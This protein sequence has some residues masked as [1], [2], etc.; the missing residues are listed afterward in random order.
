MNIRI[1]VI[2]HELLNG[3]LADTMLDTIL[4]TFRTMRGFA[5]KADARVAAEPRSSDGAQLWSVRSIWMTQDGLDGR[6]WYRNLLAATDRD[7]GYATATWPLL[8]EAILDAKPDDAGSRQR[9]LEASGAYLEAQAATYALLETL[10]APPA[11]TGG[12]DPVP[13]PRN[14]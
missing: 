7:S 10:L 9:I 14:P 4:A 1:V 12:P 8:R 2:G 13:A 5:A 6:P 3:D 11:A